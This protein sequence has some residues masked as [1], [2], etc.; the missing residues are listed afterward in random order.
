[1]ERSYGIYVE[2][3]SEMQDALENLDERSQRNILRAVNFATRRTRVLA[4]QRMRDQVAWSAAYLTGGG[5]N[6]RL[7]VQF[8]TNKEDPEARINTRFRPTSLARFVRGQKTPWKYVR[9]LEVKPG[10]FKPSQRLLIVPLRAGNQQSEDRMNL[11]LAVRLRAGETIDRKY[12][13]KELGK[14]LYL[15]YAPSVSQ[16]FYTVAE[17]VLPQAEIW[18]SEEYVR[19]MNLGDR[20]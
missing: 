4:S 7:G 18:L 6:A 8:A 17:D 15:L 9:G 13:T 1:M 11:G 10:R 19:L 20:V 12:S 16:V 14:G 2:G 3:L 5:D